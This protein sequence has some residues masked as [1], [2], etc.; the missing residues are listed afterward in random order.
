[1]ERVT[2]PLRTPPVAFWL[3][4][5]VCLVASLGLIAAAALA[6]WWRRHAT[7]TRWSIALVALSSLGGWAVIL[8]L[9]WLTRLVSDE[10][11]WVPWRLTLFLSGTSAVAILSAVAA[12]VTLRT[13][14]VRSVPRIWRAAALIWS[15]AAVTGTW[16]IIYWHLF[17]YHYY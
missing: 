3:V 8:M 16:L 11:D 10:M 5:V 1:M 13:A 7:L 17:G 2:N 15:V 6:F 4:R 14:S 12:L 9:P